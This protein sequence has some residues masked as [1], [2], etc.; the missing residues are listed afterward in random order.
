MK[1]NSQEQKLLNAGMTF[2]V[3][4]TSS[5]IP[6]I[7]RD[8]V[9]RGFGGRGGFNTMQ[10]LACTIARDDHVTLIVTNGPLDG[11]TARHEFIHCAQVYASLETM[12][13]CLAA[14]EAIGHQIIA[15]VR[16]AVKTNPP[17]ETAG[18][19]DLGRITTAWQFLKEQGANA[20]PP[21][22]ALF[23]VLHSYYPTPDTH[24]LA[25]SLGVGDP[26][27]VYAAM[28]AA[29]LNEI[30]FAIEPGSDLAREIVAYTFQATEHT[31]VDTLFADA[32]D[33]A[34]TL[35]HELR[36]DEEFRP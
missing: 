35:A 23:E 22:H 15:A 14:S 29:I 30:D 8:A 26:D 2:L 6:E 9:L 10:G 4:P 21:P 32:T 11:E 36:A 27:S 25:A 31:A 16:K 7:E 24:S 34:E 1:L 19:R 5:E 17:L 3:E 33:R 28:T 13:A 18:H 12:L 20:V